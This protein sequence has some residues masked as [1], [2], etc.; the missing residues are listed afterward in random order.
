MSTAG[1]I[2]VLSDE[3]VI[4]AL[5]GMFVEL[6]GRQPVFADAEETPA[7][8]LTRLRPLAVIVIDVDVDAARSD[9]FFAVAARKQ[10]RVVV[11][12]SGARTRGIGE[13]AAQRNIPW[14]ILPPELD[15][16][17]TILNVPFGNPKQDRQQ[18]ESREPRTTTSG[19]G[20][21]I[22]S[23]GGGRRWMV[24]D[25]VDAR[26]GRDEHAFEPP[27]RVFVGEDGETRHCEPGPLALH[28]YSASAL[29]EQ[30]G[31]ARQ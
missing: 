26:A 9:L 14:F 7:D 18:G 21:C 19:D 30:L 16:L 8:A 25:R 11:F 28:D 17:R 23:D 31:R 5:I 13:I 12:G 1:S 6:T 22:L 4:A 2:L 3:P 20:T 10:V 15:R 24:Y 27:D 29:D